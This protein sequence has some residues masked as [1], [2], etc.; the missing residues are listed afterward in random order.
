MTAD[1]EDR[2]DAAAAAETKGGGEWRR[3]NE[4]EGISDGDRL[5]LLLTLEPRVSH[6][7][8]KTRK[9]TKRQVTVAFIDMMFLT[10]HSQPLAVLTL[11]L[12]R[13][14]ESRK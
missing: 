4:A 6:D 14:R 9:T 11:F 3:G 8:E 5:L 13:V 2:A 1:S 7:D 10:L 12:T